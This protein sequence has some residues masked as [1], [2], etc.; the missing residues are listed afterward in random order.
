MRQHASKF[1]RLH[2]RNL[3]VC[4]NASQS[5]VI[6]TLDCDATPFVQP[7]VSLR[8]IKRFLSCFSPKSNKRGYAQIPSLY[9]LGGKPSRRAVVLIGEPPSQ[10]SANAVSPSLT[11]LSKRSVLFYHLPCSF[12]L[13]FYLLRQ[14]RYMHNLF[15]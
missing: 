5:R 11:K 1:Q 13:L 10:K 7:L 2:L 12:F 14:I 15:I 8:Q 4:V 9:S 3:A 6:L